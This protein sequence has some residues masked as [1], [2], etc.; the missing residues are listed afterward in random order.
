[1]CSGCE[2]VWQVLDKSLDKWMNV[3]VHWL[4]LPIVKRKAPEQTKKWFTG[5]GTH[6]EMLSRE[7]V[8]G[9][10]D[11]VRTKQQDGKLGWME[12]EIVSLK[13]RLQGQM[14][15][16]DISQEEYEERIKAGTRELWAQQQERDHASTVLDP[17]RFSRSEKGDLTTSEAS[18]LSPS[19]SFQKERATVFLSPSPS[20]QEEGAAVSM[21]NP[22]YLESG[23]AAEGGDMRFPGAPAGLEL[24]RD[25]SMPFLTPRHNTAD[26]Q[27][28]SHAAFADAA[29]SALFNSG[30]YSA[31]ADAADSALFVSG[32]DKLDADGF[33]S[34]DNSEM[35]IEFPTNDEFSLMTLSDFEEC[36]DDDEFSELPSEWHMEPFKTNPKSSGRNPAKGFALRSVLRL[37]KWMKRGK[38]AKQKRIAQQR[39][40][41]DDSLESYFRD[42]Y[43]WRCSP[44]LIMHINRTPLVKSRETLLVPLKDLDMG[45]HIHIP[46]LDPEVKEVVER[47]YT[48]LTSELSLGADQPAEVLPYS[49]SVVKKLR[50]MTGELLNRELNTLEEKMVHAQAGMYRYRLI[51]VLHREYHD[52]DH[53]QPWWCLLLHH[54][55]NKWWRFNDCRMEEI[56]IHSNK[57]NEGVFDETGNYLI[58]SASDFLFYERQSL[59]TEGRDRSP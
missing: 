3:V 45:C 10:E 35:S 37:K 6:Q 34:V 8:T 29:D 32:A 50:A 21:A 43:L 22:V 46:G 24:N 57:C 12:G 41:L 48:Q 13:T 1:M 15:A 9:V 2:G 36:G 5:K 52:E 7:A 19:P 33:G 11:L 16:G 39:S 4:E 47:A 55:T 53:P 58:A 23:A 27:Q 54:A 40:L 59:L 18:Q 25:S 20:F 42:R 56:P 26:D 38:L 14:I 28:L 31:F 17:E 44:V 30:A 49:L 51:G